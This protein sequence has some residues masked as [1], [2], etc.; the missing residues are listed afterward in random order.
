[1]EQVQIP[2]IPR[3]ARGGIVNNPGAGVMMGSYVAGE[4]GPEAVIPLDDM[5]LDR[6]GLAFARHTNITATIPVYVG[7][8]QIAREIRNINADEDFAYNK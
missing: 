2:K 1:M 3:L 4:K 8:R 7:N 6:L 5:T